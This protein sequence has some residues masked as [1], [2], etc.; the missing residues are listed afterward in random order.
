MSKTLRINKDCS[1]LVW[2]VYHDALGIKLSFLEKLKQFDF[3]VSQVKTL[4]KR[5]Y[6]EYIPLNE[7][8]ISPKAIYDSRLLKKVY[9]K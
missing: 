1:E 2:K 9:R 7:T 6:G 8:V 4:M 5:R 3:T